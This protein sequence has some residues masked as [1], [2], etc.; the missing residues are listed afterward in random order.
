MKISTTKAG[1]LALTY[2]FALSAADIARTSTAALSASHI[3]D[4]HRDW[5]ALHAAVEREAKWGRQNM[6]YALYSPYN[7]DYSNYWFAN[8]T[9]GGLDVQVLLDT[10][11]ADLWLV[12][13]KAG[14]DA[15]DGVETWDPADA[16][17]TTRMEGYTFDVGYGEGGNGVSGPVYQSE[18]CMGSAC[19]VMAVSSAKKDQGLGTFPKSGIMGLAFQGDNSVSSKK[20][21]T[22]MESL[23]PSLK[24][25]IFATQFTAE[26]DSS[27]ISLGAINFDYKAP[28]K[29]IS[30][31]SSGSAKY[32]YSWSYT[33]VGYFKNGKSLG[34]FDVV[35]DT[36]G[37]MTSAAEDIVR[38]HYDGVP[39]ALDTDGDA[40]SWTVPCG[41][42]LPD[43]DMH[44]GNATLT[45]PGHRFY[46]GNTDTKGNCTVWFVREDSTTHGLLGD[47]FFC[48]HVVV[49]NQNASTIQWASQV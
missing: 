19:T 34:K 23:A 38:G 46:N 48:E 18:V 45:I 31:D 7:L 43:L 47:P 35:F 20:Q 25:P 6:R 44:F 13:P 27:Q 5:K 2:H 10:G 22:F 40:R 17:N 41:T 3:I 29:K 30:I 42:K 33:D 49:F 36:G 8:V 28:L 24:E 4:V 26:G 12:S 1:L 39:G 14:H 37:P 32:A 21:L 16:S 11:S 15:V 9:A